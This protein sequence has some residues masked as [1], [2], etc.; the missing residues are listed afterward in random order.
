MSHHVGSYRAILFVAAGCIG[1]AVIA[2]GGAGVNAASPGDTESYRYV[3]LD[4]T[5]ARI[6]ADSGRIWILAHPEAAR[7]SLV[8]FADQPG[9]RWNEVRLDRELPTESKTAAAQP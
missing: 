5:I 2:M 3:G 4:R 9:W 6:D 1:L 7:G 8:S